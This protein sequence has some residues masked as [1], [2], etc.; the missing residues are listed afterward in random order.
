MIL[1]MLWGL[2]EDSG[3]RP[4]SLVM[5]NTMRAVGLQGKT[6]THLIVGF[7]CN[8]RVMAARTLENKRIV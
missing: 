3:Y 1:Y 8:S 6:F 7:G 5:D 4:G 2:L